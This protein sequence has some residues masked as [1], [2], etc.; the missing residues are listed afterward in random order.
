MWRTWQALHQHRM[1]SPPNSY[2]L[3]PSALPVLSEAAEMIAWRMPGL[4]P[5]RPGEHLS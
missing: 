5:S 4:S 3:H 1:L 2:E